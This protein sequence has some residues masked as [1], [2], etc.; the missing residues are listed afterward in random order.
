MSKTVARVAV[1]LIA[2]ILVLGFLQ[3]RSCQ[4]ARQQ[5]AESRVQRG[6]TEALSNSA[7]DA[8]ATQ[9]RSQAQERASEELTR[10]NE[11]EIRHAEGANDAVNPAVRDAGINALC[12]R[13]AYRNRPRCARNNGPR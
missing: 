11:K 13:E 9:G 10:S 12:R 5:A 8:L 2:I 4:Q 7:Q 6:Q 3:V 1:A